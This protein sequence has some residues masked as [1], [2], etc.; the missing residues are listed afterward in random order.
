MKLKVPCT[1]CPRQFSKSYIKRHMKTHTD[2][3]RSKEVPNTDESSEEEITEYG[4]DEEEDDAD[5]PE[6]EVKRGKHYSLN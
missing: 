3:L 6:G 5:D 2:E 1:F 4:I